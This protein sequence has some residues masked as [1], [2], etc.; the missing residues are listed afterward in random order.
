MQSKTSFSW[1][2][3][4]ARQIDII[5]FKWLI[6]HTGTW[7]NIGQRGVVLIINR[8]LPN[9]YLTQSGIK[10]SFP[11][12]HTRYLNNRVPHLVNSRIIR[13]ESAAVE[14]EAMARIFQDPLPSIFNSLGRQTERK[15]IF[16]A[17]YKKQ[18]GGSRPYFIQYTP[19]SSKDQRR[20][21]NFKKIKSFA[22]RNER[23]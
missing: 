6:H 4:D 10:T 23:M 1:F 5:P 13:S 9:S 20:W 8:T 7:C 14:T 12:A 21:W 11:M 2:R 22:Q 18:L 16:A 19:M 15:I 17:W 3:A